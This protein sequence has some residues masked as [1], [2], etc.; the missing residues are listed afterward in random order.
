M[1]YTDVANILPLGRRQLAAVITA[2]GDVV[3]VDAAARALDMDRTGAAKLL[4]RWTAQGWLRRVARG[5]YVPAPLDSL[6]SE[7]VLEDP[8][9]LVPALFAPC[10]IGGRTAAAHWDLTEQIFK[11]IVVLTARTVRAA[12][13]ERHGAEFTLKHIAKEKLFGTKSVWRGRSKIAVSDI[14]RTVIDMLD[15]PPLGGGIQHVAD[16][17]TAYLRRSDR[18]DSK[19]IE[20]GER[21][22]NGAVFKRLGFL[23]ARMPGGEPLAAASRQRLT[24]GYAKL[25]PALECPRLISRW[26]LWIPATWTTAGR[27]D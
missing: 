23:A 4:S 14:H 3:S 22:G 10:Y 2:S 18:D 20:Y 26:R 5:A 27:H 24:T 11:D 6:S 13:Q 7:H 16:C 12:S 19:L 8:W 15:D 21:L 25:D 17:V 9:V 1:E